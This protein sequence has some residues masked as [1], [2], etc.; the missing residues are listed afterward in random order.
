MQNYTFDEVKMSHV[1][2]LGAKN[3]LVSKARRAASGQG[4]ANKAG[5]AVFVAAL[6]LYE[7]WFSLV[8]YAHV[9]VKRV[10]PRKRI[11]HHILV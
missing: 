11:N 4:L 7:I 9:F 3:S 1:A 5:F 10:L 2:M 6:F 8:V